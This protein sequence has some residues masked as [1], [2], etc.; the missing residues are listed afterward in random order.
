MVTDIMKIIDNLN[1]NIEG[2][3]NSLK[4]ILD[5]DGGVVIHDTFAPITTKVTALTTLGTT[6]V[7]ALI[8]TLFTMWLFKRQEKMRIKQELKL[9]FYRGYE[10]LYKSLL[11]NMNECQK[12]VNRLKGLLTYDIEGNVV[13][14]IDG[15]TSFSDIEKNYNGT[16]EK[17]IQLFKDLQIKLED[18]EIF[19]NSKKTITGYESYKFESIKGTI[20]SINTQYSHLEFRTRGIITDKIL[21]DCREKFDLDKEAM[22]T[23][24]QVICG[25]VEKYKEVLVETMNKIENTPTI[26]NEIQTI[27]SKIENEFIGVYFK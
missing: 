10:V 2:I 9:D 17:S 3:N 26:L 4:T 12:E 21:N 20:K 13:N 5:K 15:I 23:N 14:F 1:N 27:N 7:G 25:V 6:I 18:L 22:P 24:E 8:G 16:M 11:S 19:M